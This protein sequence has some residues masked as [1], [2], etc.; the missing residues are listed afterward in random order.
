[1]FIFR[2]L[3][4]N[5]FEIIPD[6]VKILIDKK[7]DL[8]LEDSN[9]ESFH[10]YIPYVD[11]PIRLYYIKYMKK[12]NMKIPDRIVYAGYI[13][14]YFTKFNID[15]I[16]Y[17]IHLLP[18]NIF[19]MSYLKKFILAFGENN[20][21]SN[22][23]KYEFLK[24][25]ID[26]DMIDINNKYFIINLLPNSEKFSIEIFDYLVDKNIKIYDTYDY[27]EAIVYNSNY[28][29]N[30]FFEY[31]ISKIS[32]VNIYDRVGD[33]I[34]DDNISCLTDDT[35]QLLIDH[36]SFDLS[37]NGIYGGKTILECLCNRKLYSFLE[38]TF[39]KFPN[40]D[41]SSI[42]SSTD[43]KVKKI[44]KKYGYITS[45]NEHIEILGKYF[46]NTDT[47]LTDLNGSEFMMTYIY[48][49]IGPVMHKIYDE[50]QKKYNN[51][52]THTFISENLLKYYVNA[53]KIIPE[54]IHNYSLAETHL[55]VDI[56]STLTIKKHD[57]EIRYPDEADI[58]NFFD[59]SYNNI[60]KNIIG[61]YFSRGG[62][63]GATQ[64]KIKSIHVHLHLVEHYIIFIDLLIIV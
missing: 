4:F 46:L 14:N 63:I 25:L 55:V 34:Y 50:I 54:I 57:F 1:M 49:H 22:K 38:L 7:A 27:L 15:N 8:N 61:N 64:G 45:N 33:T 31:G 60:I 16:K 51:V 30:K 52:N 10:S 26:E 44:I 5:K 13:N 17:L 58:E 29:G 39:K 41:V 42:I 2:K 35:F 9:G 11:N 3:N 21:I 62:Y 59:T 19:N 20:I 18:S 43:P 28:I 36:P 47:K 24:S 32:N 6:L 53:N 56:I 48:N 40:A 37:F 12:H 23:E